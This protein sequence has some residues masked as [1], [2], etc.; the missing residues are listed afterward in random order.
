MQHLANTS[1]EMSKLRFG[2]HNYPVC[3]KPRR[4]GSAVPELLKPLRCSKHSQ[5]SPDA[6]SGILGVIAEKVPEIKDAVQDKQH[7][8]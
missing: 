2:G 4:I 6:R 3:P 5:L 7:E 8:E 1:S